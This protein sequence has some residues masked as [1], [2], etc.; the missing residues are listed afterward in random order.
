MFVTWKKGENIRGCVGNFQ[1][2]DLWEGLQEVAI[3][4]GTRDPRFPAIRSDEIP[5]LNCGVSL[6]YSFEEAKDVL[7]WEVGNH[8]VDLSIEGYSATYLPDLIKEEGISKKI[9]S[10][11]VTAALKLKDNNL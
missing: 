1:S 9:R 2:I 11:A 7:D 10:K 4:A 8:G 6:L 3:I 5:E